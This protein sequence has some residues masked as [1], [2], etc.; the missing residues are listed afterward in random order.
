MF[1]RFSTRQEF[2]AR[3]GRDVQEGNHYYGA[4]GGGGENPRAWRSRSLLTLGDTELMI[5][6]INENSVELK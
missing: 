6:Y 2:F 3:G 1:Q 5:K 4:E